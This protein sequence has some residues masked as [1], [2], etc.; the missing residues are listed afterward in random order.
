MAKRKKKPALNLLTHYASGTEICEEFE[1][2]SSR[3]AVWKKKLNIPERSGTAECWYSKESYMKLL[4]YYEY[5]MKR[6][7]E[8]EE[9][10]KGIQL[11]KNLE[12]LKKEHPLI[13]NPYCFVEG[14]FPEV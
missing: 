3:L 8:A 13:T 7:E 1:I 11:P 9:K 5:R 2:S 10:R 14:W 12:E 4:K 6:K